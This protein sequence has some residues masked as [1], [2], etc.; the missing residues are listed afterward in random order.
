MVR[1]ISQRTQR[2][3]DPRD[4]RREGKA[5]S[6][7]HVSAKPAGIMGRGPAKIANMKQCLAHGASVS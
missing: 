1:G 2:D 6:E 7:S 3:G 4:L 5:S